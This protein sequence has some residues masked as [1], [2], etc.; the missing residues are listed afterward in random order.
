MI[1]SN[2]LVIFEKS[3]DN[4]ITNRKFTTLKSCIHYGK[5]YV[6]FLELYMKCDSVFALKGNNS[7]KKPC[8]KV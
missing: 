1:F 8:K 4:F 7:F 5:M 3:D 2:N 6:I